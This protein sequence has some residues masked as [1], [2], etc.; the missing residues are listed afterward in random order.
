MQRAQTVLVPPAR[1]LRGKEARGLGLARHRR[2]E[3]VRGGIR[4]VRGRRA[5]R[6][7]S[8]SKSFVCNGEG[9]R[10]TSGLCGEGEGL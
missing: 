4:L 10:V 8:D 1:A 6:R 3:E 2:H 7:W 9:E 5:C